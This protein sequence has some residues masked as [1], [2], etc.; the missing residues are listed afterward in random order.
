MKK[1]LTG[2]TILSIASIQA[3]AQQNSFKKLP[4]GLEYMMAV[5]APGKK[6]AT[7]G[8]MIT[9]HIRTIAN[10]SSLFDSYK[11]NNNEPVPAQIQKPSFNG[12]VMEG[13][14]MLSEGD[15]AIFRTVADSV[16]RG[17]QFPPFVKSGDK[18]N[19]YV[20]MITVKSQA[21]YQKEQ[22]EAAGKQNSIDDK[23]IQDYVKANK[24]KVQKT[25]SG[26]YYIMTQKGSGE[27]AKAGQDVTMNYSGKLMDGT[28]FDSNVDPKF[29]HVTPFT[30]K[31]GSGQVIK[32]WDEG[33]ALLN[34]GAKATLIIP[35]SMAYGSRSMPGN[36]NNPKGI[37]ANS[38]LIFDV[39]MVEAK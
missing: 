21:E 4:S 30:F 26:L 38:V 24:L 18:V 15:S 12:D 8:S 9:M 3:N 7:E 6:L 35:S 5:D 16:F 37:P 39:E 31:L 13:L 29:G 27:N 25:A 34:K 10:D 23:M 14:A 32:G 17:G 1:I 11:M 33:I 20:K 28:G 19:F 22:S 2:L 36:Q